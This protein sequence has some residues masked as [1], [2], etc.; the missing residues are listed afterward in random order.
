MFFIKNKSY[1]LIFFVF[2]VLFFEICF[3][4]SDSEVSPQNY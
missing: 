4:Y 1:F 2:V 3:N